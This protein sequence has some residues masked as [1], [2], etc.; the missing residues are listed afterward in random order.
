MNGGCDHVSGKR[1]LPL[2]QEQ[3]ARLIANYSGPPQGF[4]RALI[5]GVELKR[6]SCR[7]DG[8]GRLAHPLVGVAPVVENARI[9]RIEVDRPGEVRVH[10]V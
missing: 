4:S 8:A 1:Y 9:L 3:A 7:G 6:M 10:I 5:I 2:S